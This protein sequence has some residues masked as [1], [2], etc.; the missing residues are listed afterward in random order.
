[1]MFFMCRKS[2]SK[3]NA[4][5]NSEKKENTLEE[6]IKDAFDKAEEQIKDSQEKTGTKEEIKEKQP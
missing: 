1:M 2:Q 3:K 5:D 4:T 6:E